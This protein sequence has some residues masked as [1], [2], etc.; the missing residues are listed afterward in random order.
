MV[1]GTNFGIHYIIQLNKE[2]DVYN[3]LLP[4][5]SDIRFMLDKLPNQRLCVLSYHILNER[6]MNTQYYIDLLSSLNFINY[7][8]YTRGNIRRED[9][10]EKFLYLDV[11]N[12]SRKFK[13]ISKD[14]WI[15]NDLSK[16]LNDDPEYY[17]KIVALEK[18]FTNIELTEDEKRMIDKI[19]SHPKLE[20]LIEYSQFE[21][22]SYDY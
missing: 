18:N 3:D 1:H 17:E 2:I 14:K 8:D 11:F 13:S 5:C 19:I 16:L 21:L 22:M 9:Y 10:K 7:F 12:Y 15:I 6:F 4:I 20:G